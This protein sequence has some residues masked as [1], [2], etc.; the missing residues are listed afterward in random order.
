MAFGSI[1]GEES[2]TITFKVRTVTINQ[3]ST[4]MQ[5]EILTI[6]EPLT[7]NAVARV[8][9]APPVSTEF[10]AAVRI[11]SGPSSAADLA[12]SGNSTVFQGG[13]WT[14]RS[15]L[16]STSADNPVSA[17]QSGSWTVRANLSSTSA[18]NPIQISVAST[19]FVKNIGLSVD[20]SN[21]L[22]V[23]ASLSVSALSSISSIA[24][25]VTVTPNSTAPTTYY[26]VRITDGSTWVVDYAQ[27]STF[28]STLVGGG[29]N[30]LRAGASSVSSTDVFVMPWAS[31]IGHQIVAVT[32]S[33]QAIVYPADSAN[34][35][36]RVNVVA[37]AAG[38]STIVTISALP[39]ISSGV[40]AGNSSAL[41]VRNVWSSTHT[42]QNV[43]IA[44]VDSSGALAKVGDA[45]NN[46][47]RVN[48]VA[49]AAGGSTI[50]TVSSLPM[51][52]TSVPGAAS[53]GL[54]VWMVGGNRINIGSTA[55]DNAVTATIGTNLQSTAAPSSNS[56]GLIV[57]Q[58]VDNILTVSSTNAMASTSFTINSSVA[59]AKIRIVS[60]SITSTVQSPTSFKFYS[61]GTL[62]W[63]VR[64]AALS[65]AVSGANL[66]CSAPG[67]LFCSKNAGEAVT[68]QT[69]ST[70]TNVNVAVSYYIAI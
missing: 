33:S 57:R 41:T 1:K 48:V 68:L 58:V 69:A 28:T 22:N 67:Y 47:L 39:L 50:V 53:S 45:G 20:S 31:T 7:S 21:F 66:A 38:G 24:G 18:D 60:Y 6:G 61:S 23:N 5:Q 49:G 13:S 44:A 52:S 4:N 10:G 40:P 36:I 32:D 11:V 12:V 37:G 43:N 2:A 59:N 70:V 17:A 46:A 55:A 16:S 26:P 8:L 51:V 54:N 64:L 42:D 27:G 29:V 25:V 56:S 62:L 14:V 63:P 65:S 9:A 19:A 15:N 30:F 35:A 34:N 3:N